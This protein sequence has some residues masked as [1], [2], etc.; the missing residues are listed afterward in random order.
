MRRGP[1]IIDRKIRWSRKYA[2]CIQCKT[3][4]FRYKANG[5]CFSC[6]E[7]YRYNYK[8]NFYLKNRKIKKYYK[9]YSKNIFNKKI[10]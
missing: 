5:Y 4:D 3:T 9:G 1:K 7:K 10:R 6:Y 2:L 8:H